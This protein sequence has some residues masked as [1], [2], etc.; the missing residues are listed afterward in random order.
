MG[1][2]SRNCHLNGGGVKGERR[3]WVRGGVMGKEIFGE[4]GRRKGSEPIKMKISND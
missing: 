2:C 4:E 1:G 3:I